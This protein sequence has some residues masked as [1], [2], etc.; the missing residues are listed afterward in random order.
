MKEF[1][2]EINTNTIYI[3]AIRFFGALFIGLSLGWIS[4]ELKY[5]ME[6][7]WM[8]ALSSI[9][10]GIVFAFFPGAMA[11]QS[12]TINEDGIQ[13][14]HYKFYWGERDSIKWEKISAISVQRNK[15]LIKNKVGS[16]EKISLPLHT[17]EQ[18]K[19]LKSYLKEISEFKNIEYKTT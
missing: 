15:I 3:K 1:K 13:T 18:I 17:T 7:E 5:G 12:L 6:V 19:S 10:C 16:T 8:N 9:L 11:K 2:L 4:Y 14:H